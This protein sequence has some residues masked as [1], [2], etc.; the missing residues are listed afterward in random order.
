MTTVTVS[1]AQVVIALR[2]VFFGMDGF[3][4]ITTE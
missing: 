2:S 1:A 4:L 3:V